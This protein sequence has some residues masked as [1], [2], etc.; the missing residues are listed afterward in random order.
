M[1]KR[2]RKPG[3]KNKQY[4]YVEAVRP[5]CVKCGSDKIARV[6]GAPPNVKPINGRLRD[7]TIYK[8]IKWQ[9]SVCEC[10]QCLMV[11]TYLT[12]NN[13]TKPIKPSQTPPIADAESAT[14]NS[15]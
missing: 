7:G 2:G 9:R 10:G 15:N 14:L 3:S 4:Q 8:S 11:K 12:E 1:A 6:E 5:S 13:N